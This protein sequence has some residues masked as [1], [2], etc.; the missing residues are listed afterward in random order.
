MINLCKLFLFKTIEPLSF[1]V[2]RMETPPYYRL[3]KRQLTVA[4]NN[5]E[6]GLGHG[7]AQQHL[8]KG[9]IHTKRHSAEDPG[10]LVAGDV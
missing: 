3:S 10:K 6:E 8:D 1:N 2:E 4:S 9:Q 7:D 5:E